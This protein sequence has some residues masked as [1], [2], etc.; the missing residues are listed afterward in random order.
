MNI[1]SDYEVTTG[2]Y[3]DLQKGIRHRKSCNTLRN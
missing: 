1:A 2:V 3:L